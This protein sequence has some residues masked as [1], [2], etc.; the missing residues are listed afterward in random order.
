[1]LQMFEMSSFKILVTGGAGFVGSHLALALKEKFPSS[2][3]IAL[4]NLKRRGSEL[5]LSRLSQGGV[6]FM[7][8]DVRNPGDLGF[9]ELDWI[10]ECSAEPSALAGRFGD[11]DYLV[12]TN[13]L[14]TYHCL[15]LARRCKAGIIFLSSSRVY[16]IAPISQ[17][18]FVELQTRFVLEKAFSVVG[19][20]ASGITEEFPLD[21]ARTLYGTTKLAS[22]LLVQEYAETFSLPM[23]IN[24]CGVLTGP[25]QMG[26]ID[27]GVVVLWMARHFLGGKL[28]YIGYGGSGKQVR[29]LLHVADLAELV[30]LQMQDIEKHRGQT[31][32]VGGGI[33]NSISLVELTKICQELTGQEITMEVDPVDRPGDVPWFVTDSSK[34]RE[35]T[36]WNPRHSLTMTLKE[37]LDWLEEHQHQLHAILS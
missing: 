8:G 17:F 10:I 15:E 36:G 7:H 33:E 21:G 32:N 13:L 1:M 26:K 18:P 25:W 31:Y 28:S 16:P 29:D 19:A 35:A 4:D 34:V 2:K 11:T 6:E 5:N 30:A 23:V 22:E 24:R 37:I 9:M 14:G 27:Q 12:H 20:S 3:V